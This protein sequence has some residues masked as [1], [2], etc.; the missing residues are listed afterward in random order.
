[1]PTGMEK[2]EETV[3]IVLGIIGN[4]LVKMAENRFAAILD[5]S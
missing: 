1:M 4:F 2:E 5:A 3:I